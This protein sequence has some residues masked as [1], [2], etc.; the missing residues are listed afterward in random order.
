MNLID[1]SIVFVLG[2]AAGY[3]LRAAISVR[4]R[5]DYRLRRAKAAG[6]RP[7]KVLLVDLPYIPATTFS[8]INAEPDNFPLLPRPR[9]PGSR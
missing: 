7:A 3:I 2:A 1:F 9:S 5:N 4:R 8:I 6:A